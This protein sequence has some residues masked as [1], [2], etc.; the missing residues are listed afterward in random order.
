ME[1]NMYKT[2]GETYPDLMVAA[3]YAEIQD[4]HDGVPNTDTP[5][6]MRM[7]WN[8]AKYVGCATNNHGI[9]VCKYSPVDRNTHGETLPDDDWCLLPA[10]MADKNGK[11]CLERM[12][13]K[14]NVDVCL[15]YEST[16]FKT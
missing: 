12:V 6:Y 4:A 11:D 5:N 3:W 10:T 9:T 16:G 15:P 1:E 7:M 2:T 13:N 8:G 14:P